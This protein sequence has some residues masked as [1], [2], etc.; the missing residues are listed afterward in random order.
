M[1]KKLFNYFTL[2]IINGLLLFVFACNNEK[3]NAAESESKNEPEHEEM[4]MKT[5]T[6]KPKENPYKNAQID[7]KIFNNDTIKNSGLQGFGYDIYMYRSLYVHQPAIPA[8]NGNRGFDNEE[9]A[10]KTA[11][12]VVYKLKNNIMPPSV[13]VEELDSLGVLK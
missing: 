3:K 10:R 7:I 12:L 11:E 1:K 4:E 9:D 5:D 6:T 8:I 2:V 13:K